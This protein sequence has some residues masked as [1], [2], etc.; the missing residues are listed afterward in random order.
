MAPR[1]YADLKTRG[2]SWCQLC[3]NYNHG[4]PMTISIFG[5]LLVNGWMPDVFLLFSSL[6]EMLETGK[7][8][9]GF[10]RYFAW[11][12]VTFPFHILTKTARVKKNSLSCSFSEGTQVRV[13]ESRFMF[14]VALLNIR[15][16]TEIA[17]YVVR[18]FFVVVRC[19]ASWAWVH[20]Y[21]QTLQFDMYK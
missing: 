4:T 13:P 10:M 21:Y 3:Y 17:C 18:Y 15:A 1:Y 9:C 12:Y 8:S 7:E 16:V 5:G 14:T 11:F 2:F 6:I 19:V 20:R